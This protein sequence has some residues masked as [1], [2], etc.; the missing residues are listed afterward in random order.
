MVAALETIH[1]KKVGASH[2]LQMIV[3]TLEAR[4]P[5]EISLQD[6]T[7]WYRSNMTALSPV[8][9]LQIKLRRI[10]LGEKSWISYSE[11]RRKKEKMSSVKFMLELKG[12]LAPLRAPIGVESTISFT[13]SK[14]KPV[15]T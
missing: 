5:F 13:V 4:F 10:I 8:E 1:K 12:R 14:K 9:I 7:S 11:K 6:F 2:N 3:G 15:P